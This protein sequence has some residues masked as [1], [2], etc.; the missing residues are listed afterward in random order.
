LWTS[1]IHHD[2]KRNFSGL[3]KFLFSHIIRMF[4]LSILVSVRCAICS[5]LYLN[6][7]IQIISSNMKTISKTS[8]GAASKIS[9]KRQYV[10]SVHCSTESQTHCREP[11][12][13][14]PNNLS[15]HAQTTSVLMPKQPLSSCPNNLSPHAQTTEARPDVI[16]VPYTYTV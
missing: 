10:D 7:K 8:N 1:R 3:N 4:F 12:S 13:P 6:Q 16:N 11:Q 15:P 14:C 2:D 5:H 9:D